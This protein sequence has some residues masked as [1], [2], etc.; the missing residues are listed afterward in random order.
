MSERKLADMKVVDVK[1]KNKIEFTG[2]I[3]DELDDF[4][5][6][7]NESRRGLKGKPKKRATTIL[8]SESY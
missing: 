1:V 5:I 4:T 6:E 2:R 7:Q 3:E 8:E